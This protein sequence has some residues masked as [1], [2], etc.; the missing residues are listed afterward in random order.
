MNTALPAVTLWHDA[1]VAATALRTELEQSG[2]RV[3]WIFSGGSVPVAAWHG[4]YIHGF[5]EIRQVLVPPG[6]PPD[7]VGAGVVRYR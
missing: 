1:S 4:L 5:G 2:Y 7:S 3:S 6:D